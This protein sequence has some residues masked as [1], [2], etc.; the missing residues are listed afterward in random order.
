MLKVAHFW[1]SDN[2][3]L[4][5]WRTTTTITTILSILDFLIAGKTCMYIL[6]IC[7]YNYKH[8]LRLSTEE[9]VFIG[10]HVRRTDWAWHLKI[11][12]GGYLIDENFFLNGMRLFRK[13]FANKVIIFVFASDDIEWCKEKFSYDQSVYFPHYKIKVIMSI[14]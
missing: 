5:R 2:L 9:L 4:Q 3:S 12:I 14:T 11:R 1:D 10:V 13:M 7:T 6:F 8:V